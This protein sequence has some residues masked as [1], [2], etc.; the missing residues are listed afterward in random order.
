MPV[1]RDD[2]IQRVIELNRQKPPS[3]KR[4]KRMPK[5]T[6]DPGA[7]AYLAAR[8]KAIAALLTPV[9][10][11]AGAKAGLGFSDEVSVSI[12]GLLA[13]AIVYIVPNSYGKG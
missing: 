5:T 8:L 13:G 6:E 4:R 12:A 9:V 3:P 10:A 11:F 1:N 2:L 7:A